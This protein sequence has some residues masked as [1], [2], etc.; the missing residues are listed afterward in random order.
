MRLVLPVEN[1]R[2]QRVGYVIN[3]SFCQISG[4]HCCGGDRQICRYRFH[5]RP[6]IHCFRPLRIQQIVRV[7][8]PGVDAIDQYG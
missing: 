5:H 4:N 1:R 8:I 3:P 2:P 6:D 7:A